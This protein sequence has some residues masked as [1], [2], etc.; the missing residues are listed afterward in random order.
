MVRL[1]CSICFI[2]LCHL[3]MAQEPKLVIPFGHTD[4]IT[5]YC[6]TKDGKIIFSASKD[7]TVKAWDVETGT[8]LYSLPHNGKV[9]SIS[10]IKH[11]SCILSGDDDSTIYLWDL[12]KGALVKKYKIG[13]AIIDKIQFSEITNKILV[14]AGN[15]SSYIFSS[16]ASETYTVLPGNQLQ[17]HDAKGIIVTRS[18]TGISS[19]RIND[20]TLSFFLPLNSINKIQLSTSGDLLAVNGYNDS[21]TL[22]A[23]KDFKL[24]KLFQ[25]NKKRSLSYNQMLFNRADDLLFAVEPFDEMIQCWEIKTGVLHHYSIKQNQRMNKYEIF[26]QLYGIAM[27]NKSD[28]SIWVVFELVLPDTS[29]ENLK[30]KFLHVNVISGKVLNSFTSDKEASASILNIDNS[31]HL[32]LPSNR[33]IHI[34]DT[35]KGK[36]IFNT[37]GAI[38]GNGVN[39]ISSTPDRK[40]LI[41]SADD[42]RIRVLEAA[43]GKIVYTVIGDYFTLDHS[44]K[45]LLCTR[46]SRPFSQYSTNIYDVKTGLLINE[47]KR[48]K[49]DDR[50]AV[51]KPVFLRQ[52]SLILFDFKGSEVFNDS[53]NFRQSDIV[54]F[55][56][57]RVVKKLNGSYVEGSRYSY[58]YSA[59]FDEERSTIISD[60]TVIWDNTNNKKAFSGD[61]QDIVGHPDGKQFLTSG[62]FSSGDYTLYE[63]NLSASKVLKELKGHQEF[64]DYFS[65]SANTQYIFSASRDGNVRIWNAETGICENSFFVASMVVN[66]Y[67]VLKDNRVSKVLLSSKRDIIIVENDR[68]DVITL[69]DK[70]NN[71]LSQT[72]QGTNPIL[73]ASGDTLTFSQGNAVV[74]FTLSDRSL[75]YK[76]YLLDSTNYICV[77]GSFR[78]DGPME[79]RKKLYFTCGTEVISLDQVKDK[80]WVP[81]LAERIMHGDTIN[82]PSLSDINICGLTPLVEQIKTNDWQFQ[83]KITPRKGGLG[84][85]LVYINNIEA[86]RITK[87]QLQ[88]NGNSYQLNIPKKDLEAFWLPNQEN[89][90]A[91]K[92]LTSSNDIS[93]RSTISKEFIT[94]KQEQDPPNLFAVVVG[95]SDY[96][97]EDLDLKYAA[98]DAADIANAIQ[99]SASKLLNVEGKQHVFVSRL[100][101][102]EGRDKFPEKAAIRQVFNEIGTK[103]KPNDILLIFFAGHGKWETKANQFFFLTGDASTASAT[104]TISE[105]GISMQELSDWIQPAKIRA[106]KR[107]LVFDACNSGQAINDLVKVGENNQ[108]YLAARDDSKAEQTKAVEKL[109]DKSGLF[110]LSASA[111]NQFAYEMGRYSQGLLTYALLKAIKEQPDILEDKRFLNVSR[112]FNSAEKTVENIAAQSG[113]QQQPQLVSTTNF[114][115]G[116]VDDE[117]RNSITLHDE[118]PMFGRSE[119]RNLDTRIDNLKLRSLVD[120]VLSDISSRSLEAPITYQQDYE[121]DEVYTLSGDYSINGNTVILKAILVQGGQHIKTSFEAK[122]TIDKLK[123]LANDIANKAVAWIQ[124][125]NK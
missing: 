12:H 99:N 87:E 52:D 29:K 100:H 81:N 53:V 20:L 122:G 94:K 35:E 80:L 91:V 58:Y 96:K 39:A 71:T 103:A 77:D 115:I 33:H 10:L 34:Y 88:K 93:S 116:I 18:K 118:K 105:V 44:G 61:I 119:F 86:R 55:F 89:T 7:A 15:D 28:S 45:Y 83:F 41:V 110:I 56:T 78:Y 50:F 31:N 75:L 2:T 74:S 64:I 38:N 42:R 69:W 90:L 22:Y 60:S 4:E 70:T 95:V 13:T 17:F 49:Y 32:T 54:N 117:V 25:S 106:Q 73:D 16:L 108:N 121:G 11:D 57:G 30:T 97:G 111:S 59:V 125:N 40:N 5:D 1:L 68:A 14:S 102:G 67:S 82:A 63:V 21:I 6:A 26:P 104:E 114:N 98:K 66:N 24:L 65:Y 79:A 62:S 9:K 23:T 92:A 120:K 37:Y 72:F 3:L 51:V 123:D 107:I 109:N 84:E 113:N 112:W 47:I 43:T 46:Y 27:D 8:L 36:E 48:R 85:T 19:F 124:Q 101:T 76:T